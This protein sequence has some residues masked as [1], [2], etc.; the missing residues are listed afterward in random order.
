MNHCR[1]ACVDQ[2]LKLLEGRVEVSSLREAP[3]EEDSLIAKIG[4]YA[5]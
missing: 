1:V 4:L 2:A 5:I 3:H